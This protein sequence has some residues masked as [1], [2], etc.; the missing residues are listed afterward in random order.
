MGMRIS[1]GRVDKVDYK[2]LDIKINKLD[3]MN[4][5]IGLLVSYAGYCKRSYEMMFTGTWGFKY[6]A[7]TAAKALKLGERISTDSEIKL[8]YLEK[9]HGIKSV[10]YNKKRPDEILEIIR[11]QLSYGKPTLIFVVNYW[12]PWNVHYK[13]LNN[14]LYHAIL[15]KGID[16]KKHCLYC[17]DTVFMQEKAVLPIDDFKNG[18]NDTC[19]TL[20]CLNTYEEKIDWQEALGYSINKLRRGANTFRVF[21]DMRRFS[22]EV[23]ESL[24]IREEIKVKYGDIWVEPLIFEISELV[25]DRMNYSRALNYM[26]DKEN[27]PEL[28]NISDRLKQIVREWEGIRGMIVKGYYAS[29]SKELVLR[30]ADRIDKVADFE[31]DTANMISEII[32]VKED[33]MPI[34]NFEIKPPKK[35]EKKD[36][37]EIFYVDLQKEFNTQSFGDYTDK[38]CTANMSG[39]GYF[40][41]SDEA[42]KKRVWETGWMKFYYPEIPY[43]HKDSVACM[44]QKITLPGGYFDTIMFMGCGDLGSFSE[45]ACVIY[46]DGTRQTFFL[47]FSEHCVEKPLYNESIVWSGK[48]GFPGKS[49]DALSSR[50]YAQAYNLDGGK[51][52]QSVLLP[53]C[54]NIIIFA[55]S[56]GREGVENKRRN[57]R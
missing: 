42:L 40:L 54:P 36:L 29:P 18:C 27:V 47:Q 41:Y 25:G 32:C 3:Y 34:K 21:D 13:K 49:E 50:I 22:R 14:G 43:N 2:E 28:K 52:M 26:A 5:Y 15:V 57:L 39:L 37:D 38:N 8:D 56:L 30:I 16:T 55:I 19:I 20:E 44:G 4:C 1:K 17:L 10:K 12:F 51:M 6:T 33:N 9:Y 24:V 11:E 45:E 53:V 23:R 31:E 46:A 7:K 48:C 35:G